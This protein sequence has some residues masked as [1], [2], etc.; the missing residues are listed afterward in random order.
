MALYRQIHDHM[1]G[2]GGRYTGVREGRKAMRGRLR[3]FLGIATVALLASSCASKADLAKELAADAANTAHGTSRVA[4]T[5]TMHSPGM[6][7]TFT[8][9]GAFDYAHSRGFLR[10]GAA[11][12]FSQEVFLPPHV[13]LK[14]SGDGGPPLPRG[15]SWID[16]NLAHSDGQSLMMPGAFPGAPQTSPSDMLSYLFGISTRVTQVG[17]AT[18]RGVQTVHYRVSISLAKARSK[19]RPPARAGFTAF[20]K[21][22]GRSALPAQVWVDEQGRVRRIT[23]TLAPPKSSGVPAGTTIT[24]TVEFY[25]FGIPVRVSAPPASEVLSASAFSNGGHASGPV[26]GP[27]PPPPA[28]GTLSPAAAKAA[29]R[30]VRAFWTGIGADDPK[31]AAQAV[32]PAQRRCF[33]AFMKSAPRIKVTS[34]EIMSARPDGTARAVVIYRMAARGQVAGHSFP[35]FPGVSWLPATHIANG[36]YVDLNG[37]GTFFP[38]C[39]P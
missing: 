18:I 29:E 8:Q 25:D 6:S 21:E 27:A 23:I 38:S 12:A 5:V 2:H 14:L 28:S 7:L 11:G 9:T 33:L 19:V 20:A 3:L 36:W 26:S 16:V 1:I 31:A 17:T 39:S 37:H 34:L 15:K 22:F 30:A 24:Q 32:A 35:V 13:Y 10:A 4:V